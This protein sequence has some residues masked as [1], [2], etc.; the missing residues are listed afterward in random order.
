MQIRAMTSKDVDRAYQIT[1]STREKSYTRE[2]MTAVGITED[3]VRKMLDVDHTHQ[4]WVCEVE[5]QMVGFAMGNKST[6]EFWVIAVLP[7]FEHRGIGTSLADKIEGGLRDEGKEEAW[8]AVLK[9]VQVDG[10]AFF[11][12]RGWQDGEDRGPFRVMKKKL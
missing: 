1:L 12:A 3:S 5:N 2:G 7:D 10:Y 6:T 4:G 11:K 8:L 9:E